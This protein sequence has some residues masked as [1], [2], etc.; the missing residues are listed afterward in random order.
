MPASAR[1]PRGGKLHL[2]PF[3]AC[4]F[5]S[6]DLQC[7]GLLS[8]VACFQWRNGFKAHIPAGVC[9]WIRWYAISATAYNAEASYH[10]FGST[11]FRLLGQ[12]Y[13]S[14]FQTLLMSSR[15]PRRSG[16]VHHWGREEERPV[17][18]ERQDVHRVARRWNDQCE[19]ANSVQAC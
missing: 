18:G 8:Q 12:P 15:N 3:V 6:F 4:H 17:A 2:S 19:L 1:Y 7:S 13:C 16:L 9:S 5:Q 11:T 10:L 14:E